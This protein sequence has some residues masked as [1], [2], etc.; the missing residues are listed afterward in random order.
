MKKN[1]T[2]IFT[3][4]LFTSILLF[5]GCSSHNDI[6][7]VSESH[8]YSYQ[9]GVVQNLQADAMINNEILGENEPTQ[10]D[11]PVLDD[12]S[13]FTELVVDSDAFTAD[14]YVETAEVITYKHA[15]ES[16]FSDK[17][18]WKSFNQ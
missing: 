16:E 2:T 4:S 17:A 5:N 13:Y 15:F 11:T 10:I 3:I 6:I 9:Y 18:E 7:S 8:P 14:K 1:Q 12:P